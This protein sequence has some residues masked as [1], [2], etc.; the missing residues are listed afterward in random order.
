MDSPSNT[1]TN[2]TQGS[3]TNGAPSAWSIFRSIKNSIGLKMLLVSALTLA[4]SVPMILVDSIL[5][6]RQARRQE[7]EDEIAS[8]WAHAQTLV[9]PVLNIP[10]SVR[11]HDEEGKGKTAIRYV[12]YLPDRLNV[13]V[14]MQPETRY[15][16]IYQVVVYRAHIQMEGEFPDVKA[17]APETEHAEVFYDQ[18]FVSLGINDLRGIETAASIKWNDREI[19][20]VPG[21]PDEDL[22][23]SGMQAPLGPSTDNQISKAQFSCDLTLRGSSDF[24]VVP[25]GKSTNVSITA[26]WSNP[27]FSGSFLPSEREI[28]DKQFSAT[29]NVLNV[30]RNY[31]QTWVG[32]QYSIQESAFGLSLFTAVDNYTK[33]ERAEKYSILIVGLTFLVY[34]FLELRNKRSVHIVQYGL[35]GLALCIF[36]ILLLSISEHLN[37]DI[38]YLIASIMTIGLITWFSNS[39][40]NQRKLAV[41]I[42]ASLSVL[43][44][45][46]F[47][48]LQLQDYALLVGSIALF[49]VLAVVMQFSKSIEWQGSET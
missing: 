2:A 39:V 42:G 32:N 48:I 25:I 31:P 5:N 18:A 35:V 30:N 15:R 28:T 37:F 13:K 41:T 33:T 1:S 38:A 12:H 19:A 6:E 16:G 29:W 17:L 47:S 10:F 26:P 22:S 7:A 14:S 4:L 44:G 45:F 9:G 3:A 49:I 8:K 27:S 43:Y 46:V 36:Y 20:C 11:I 24:S 21:L 34:L 23:K 40:F